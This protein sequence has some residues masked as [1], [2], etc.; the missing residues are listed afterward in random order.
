MA[1]EPKKER[2]TG[3]LIRIE[4]CGTAEVS[5]VFTDRGRA[6]DARS[7]DQFKAKNIVGI[8]PTAPVPAKPDPWHRRPLGILAL[9]VALA[10]IVMAL[11]FAYAHFFP[12]HPIP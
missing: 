11:R 9:G 5:N 2:G 8:K 10:A 1:D 7:I 4:G 6:V 3:A 12:G